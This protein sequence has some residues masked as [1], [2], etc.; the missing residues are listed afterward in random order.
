MIKRTKILNFLKHAGDKGA[1]AD[2]VER[3]YG[4]TFHQRFFDLKKKGFIEYAGM[5]RLTRLN[6]MAKVYKL[7]ENYE[8]LNV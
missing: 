6:K 4:Y 7:C 3:I 5:T 8:N 1:T 2:E